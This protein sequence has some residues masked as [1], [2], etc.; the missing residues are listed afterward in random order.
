MNAPLAAVTVSYLLVPQKREGF[1]LPEPEAPA[2]DRAGSLAR[3]RRR[4][5]VADHRSVSCHAGDE[6]RSFDG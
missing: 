6:L 2:P 5:R 1:D 4:G 3:P